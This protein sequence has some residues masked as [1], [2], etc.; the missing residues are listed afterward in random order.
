MSA[1][2]PV[3]EGCP[4]MN[5]RS[6]PHAFHAELSHFNAERLAPE[7]IESDWQLSIR[8][9]LDKRAMERH[10]VEEERARVAGQAA[11]A[12]R[13]ASAFLRWFEDLRVH[14]PGQGDSLFPW[15]AQSATLE[16]MRWFLTQEAAGEAGFDDLVAMTQVKLPTRAKLEM[17]RNYW[18]E[19]GRGHERGMHGLMLQRTVNE[20]ELRP[21]TEDTVW[22][23]LALGNLMVALATNRRYAYQ[24][25]GA[26]GAIEM[27]APTRVCFVNAG[28][29]RLQV[30]NTARL[31]FQ[32]HESLDRTHSRKWNQEV[33]Y[34]LVE[35]NPALAQPIAEGALMR[36]VC[37][38]RCFERYRTH[39]GLIAEPIAN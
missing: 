34:S 11:G 31:Y 24:S 25:I 17:A 37:G 18:D 38:A 12:P 36:L 35:A 32:L 14:G 23:S 8:T 4:V 16:Q 9:E 20:L 15:L 6:R 27:T 1:D 13:D 19:M 7:H 28:L 26:L 3:L 2:R 22:E 39:F 33:L 10:F 5:P 30:S 21:S 29:R